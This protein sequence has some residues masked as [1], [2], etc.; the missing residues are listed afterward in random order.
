MLAAAGILA[1]AVGMGGIYLAAGPKA[2]AG[3]KKYEV[4]VIHKDGSEKT[5]Q[6]TSDDES[7]G[8]ALQKEGIIHG[9][10][11]ASGLFVTEVDG[12]TAVYEQDKAYWTFMVNGERSATGVD[13]TPLEDGAVYTWQYT[14]E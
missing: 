13:A 2:A 1:A 10:S 9:N 5:F 6:L 14:V 11:T 12:E 4:R 8:T 7:V 3:T